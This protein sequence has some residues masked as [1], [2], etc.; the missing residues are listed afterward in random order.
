MK[1]LVFLALLCL[2]ATSV[3]SGCAGLSEATEH[4]NTGVKLQE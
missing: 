2:V 4:Y 1:T 3:L